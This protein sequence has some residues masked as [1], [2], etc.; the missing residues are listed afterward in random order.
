[1]VAAL[2]QG[3]TE[4][5][6]SCGD[7]H[8]LFRLD[9]IAHGR[10]RYLLAS[11]EMP[12]GFA[13]LRVHGFEGLRIVTEENKSSGRGHRAACGVAHTGLDIAPSRLVSFE[14]VSQ[15]DFLV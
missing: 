3:K 9:C 2:R 8:V 1:M 4:N 12:K 6:T 11:I 13:C 14:R 7:C 15:Q 5:V 10:C